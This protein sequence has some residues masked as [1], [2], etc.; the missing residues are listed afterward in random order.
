MVTLQDIKDMLN[1]FKERK[2]INPTPYVIPESLY[3]DLVKKGVINKDST[4]VI[5][6]KSIPEDILI[7]KRRE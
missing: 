6:S 5:P 4:F 7:N 2:N 1:W 3:N